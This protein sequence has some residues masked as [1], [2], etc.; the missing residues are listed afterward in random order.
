[1]T[2]KENILI[3]EDEFIVG[4]DLRLMLIK[5]GY[6]VCGI[7]ASVDEAKAMI[8][9]N[10]PTW[11]LLDIFLLDGSL[12]TD[13]AG[14]LRQ[15]NIGF[16]YISANTNQSILEI[17]RATRPYGFLVKPFREKD[18]LIMLDIARYKHQNNLQLS[19]QREQ[20]MQKQLQQIIEAPFELT[21]KIARIPDV[22]QTFVPFDYLH[23]AITGKKQHTL[24]ELSFQRTGYDE[25]EQLDNIALCKT[26]GL[27]R[28]S[29]LSEKIAQL[30]NEKGG[31]LND[32]E[33]RLWI[34]D[35]TWEGKLGNH[36]RLNARLAVAVMLPAGNIA[37]IS[38][39]SRNADTYTEEQFTLLGRMENGIR[40]LLE[41]VQQKYDPLSARIVARKRV[42]KP[43]IDN[44]NLF[45]GIV[46]RSPAFLSV[47]HSIN[48]VS[49]APSSVLILGESGTGK[50]LIARCIHKQSPRKSKPL[51]TV[52]CAAL[53]AELIESE[54]FGHEKGAFTGA[55]DKRAGKFELADGGTIFLDEIGELPVE[56]QV[57]L[58]R[59][60]QEKEFERVGGS[61]VIKIDVRVIAAT[62]RNLEKEVAEGRFRLD[63]YY[64]LNVFPVELPSLRER[65]DDIPL[66]A[67]HFVDKLSEK[68][69]RNVTDISPDALK[70]L[71]S[72]DW[73]GNIREMEHVMER[74]LLMTIG[75]VLKQIMLP[76]VV[77]QQV[78]TTISSSDGNRI[79]TLEEMEIEHILQVLKSCKGKVCGVGGAAELLG[80][81]PSTLNSK[82][83]K[84]GIK[85]DFHFKD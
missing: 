1:M 49:A 44:D 81:P 37:V 67:Q 17:A 68:L 30:Q 33:F 77:T 22:L 4:N 80:L 48:M 19:L 5:A 61:K 59:V 58:L 15:K 63:L 75:T 55:T 36:L 41:Q 66:L 64:R 43:V 2:M 29:I 82:I 31:Y 42:E 83:R 14:Y 40:Q 60:L 3:V 25:Y 85:R 10:K 26:L 9:R 45:E 57:K 12:G 39:Y 21:D 28:N 73:P 84:L 34:A 71:R 56:S 16:I 47:L 65:K 78:G 35:K 51:I 62:N 46:G 76:K 32:A 11:V 53:P 18:L 70:A 52:N 27:D 50:E 74:S 6:A 72:Y 23:I 79:K 69:S 54:L 8:E 20:L 38:F 24:E 13:L 7:A